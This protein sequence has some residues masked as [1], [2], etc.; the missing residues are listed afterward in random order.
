MNIVEDILDFLAFLF[1]LGL[2]LAV[3]LG[4]ILPV[5]YE[6]PERASVGFQDKTSPVIVGDRVDSTYDGT[7]SRLEI[8]LYT[9]VQDFDMPKPK[10]YRV[11]S[12]TDT[13]KVDI[14][15]QAQGAYYK[16]SYNMNKN[17]KDSYDVLNGDTDI[18][19]RYEFVYSTN[20]TE[21]KSDDFYTFRERR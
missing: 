17:A 16:S 7:V 3:G 21:D 12:P 15:V 10:K 19:T 18:Q 5:V 1:F 9:Q 2:C 13:R 20:D 4:L 11:E 8:A 6:N 14:D